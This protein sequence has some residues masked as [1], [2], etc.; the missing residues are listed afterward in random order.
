MKKLKK[1]TKIFKMNSM[2][3]FGNETLNQF[4]KRYKCRIKERFNKKFKKK[5]PNIN[6]QFIEINGFYFSIFKWIMASYLDNFR[7]AKG[8]WTHKIVSRRTIPIPYFD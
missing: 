3:F 5:N 7:N 2:F 8:E 6:R 1:K 4:L